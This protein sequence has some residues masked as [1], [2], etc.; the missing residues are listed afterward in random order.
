VDKMLENL[1]QK[2]NN[3][4]CGASAFVLS[5]SSHVNCILKFAGLF[6]LHFVFRSNALNIP[7]VNKHYKLQFRTAKNFAYCI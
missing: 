5:L 4:Q 7:T 6:R 3:V 1:F 2:H